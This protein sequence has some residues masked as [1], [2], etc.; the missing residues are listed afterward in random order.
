[1]L[2]GTPTNSDIGTNAF[3]VSLTDTNGLSA[4]ASMNILVTA[5]PPPAFLSNPFSEP[6]ANLAENYAGDIATNGTAPFLNAG[7]LLTFAKVSGPAWLNVAANGTLSGVPDVASAG[8][9]TFL[10]SVTDLG[11]ASNTAALFI[12]VNSPPEFSPQYFAKPP[13]T[14][15]VPYS[16]AIATNAF[17]PDIPA[18]DVLTFYKVSG[19]AWLNV[20]TNGALSGVP[21]SADG[22]ET[23]LMLVVDSGGLAGVGSM[24]ITVNPDQPPQFLANPFSEPPAIAGQSY[25]A[26]MATNA[27]DPIAGDQLTFSKISGPAWL[28]VAASGGLSGLP[29]TTNAGANSFVVSVQDV[30]GLSANATMLINITAVP[31]MLAIRQQGTN[32]LLEWSGGVPPYQ[33]LSATNPGA[34]WQNSGIPTSQTNLMLAPTNPAAFYRV[35]GR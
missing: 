28:S 26:T 5:D 14:V 25:S 35:Q 9:N 32:V 24:S 7:D 33:V 18:G 30:G 6:W 27:F 10:V 13:A 22:P 11:G 2:S 8:T 15:G 16:G 31:M 12:Y 3:L 1:M 29:L 17:D 19:P 20:A 34:G 4:S 21:T 23:W